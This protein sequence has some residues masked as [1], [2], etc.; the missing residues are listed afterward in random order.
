MESQEKAWSYTAYDLWIPLETLVQE[1]EEKLERFHRELPKKFDADVGKKVELYIDLLRTSYDSLYRTS[2]TLVRDQAKI[3]ATL[4]N[5]VLPILDLF[6]LRDLL[7]F[8]LARDAVNELARAAD[9]ARQLL[10]FLIDARPGPIAQRYL[11]RVARCYTWG[12]D[13]E[14][15]ILCRSV[16][17]QVLEENVSD[18]DVFTAFAW[19][20]EVFPPSRQDELRK[21]D[22][23]RIA[24]GDRIYAAQA[25]GKLTNQEVELAK[26]IRD[27]GNKAVHEAP[28]AGV[29]TYGTVRDLMGV[30][31]KL[32]SG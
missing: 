15:L 23:F 13:A 27:R 28:P 9:R 18:A 22:P 7:Q 12:Y 17:Q 5:D 29:D 24:I 8:N 2:Q 32:C 20:P 26:Q 19:K 14:A 31:S 10:D 3:P 6:Y 11:A 21:H 16:L 25:I 30:I 1:E 4:K